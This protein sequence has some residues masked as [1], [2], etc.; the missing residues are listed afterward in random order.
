MTQHVQ[1]IN[2]LAFR[3]K[4]EREKLSGNNFNDWFRQLKLVLRVE[5]KMY[6]IEQPLPAAPAADSAAN[7]QAGVERFDLIQTFHA[8]KQEEGKS[9]VADNLQIKGYVDQLE[10]L[11]Y[12]LPQ[13]LITIGKL[14]AMLIEYEKGLPKNDETPQVMMIKDGKIQ[15]SKKKLL[16][17]KGKGKANGKENDKQLYIPKPKNPKPSAK[18]HPTKDDTCHHCKEVGHWKRNCL[19]YLTGV[20]EKE[21]SWL[22]HNGIHE[23]DMHDLIP[24]DNSIYD[25][26]TKRA[27]HNLDSTYLWHFHLAHISKKRI[28]KLQ[29]ER[30]LKSTNDGSFDQCVSCLSG[31]MTR[32][33]FLHRPER[34]TDL[35]GIIHIDMCGPLRHV[36]RQGA[37]Y[38]I[39]LT[40]DYSR[41][42][43]VYLLRHKHEVF[44]TFEEFKNEVENQLGK[45]I[46]ALR[47]DQG[48]EYISQEFKDHLKACG[49][50]QQ[51]THPYTPQ[52]NGDY[53]LESA[54]RILNIVPTKK[55]DKTP[56]KLC[57]IPMEVEDF[58]PSQE[59]VIIIRRFKRTNRTPNR[60]CLNVE[61]KEHTLGDLNE[62]A[63]YKAAMLDS[64]SNKWIDAMNAEIQS[65]IDNMVDY[66]ETVSPVTDIRAIRILI[67][68]SSFYDYEI[69]QID[70]KTAFLNGYFDEGIFMVQPEDLGEATFILGIK[71]YKDRS[72]RLIGL[73][74]NAY[75][76]KILKRY[77]IDNS[78]RGHIPMQE[79]L[80]LNK[81]QGASTPKEVKCMQKVPY[82]SA[83]G[84]IMY[85]VFS[86]CM[87][88]GGNTRDLGSFGEETV[89]ITDLHQIIEEAFLTKRIDDVASI[90][91]RRRDPSGNGVWNLETASG[92]DRLKE[93]L[94][95]ST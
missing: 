50:I 57:E 5:K 14:H 43:Y 56:Y 46:K 9:V 34:E 79:R 37:S 59:E 38:F 52:H 2:H 70:V 60:L 64:K 61:V 39:T 33:S 80:D 25:V 21:A 18:E 6:V 47:S 45:T 88:F 41:Y 22:C 1:N 62:P 76:D 27:K 93:D 91:Q 68:I 44:E 58:E 89:K 69:W 11:G 24:N 78:K 4:F 94:E 42:G 86:T 8:C 82:A 65:M 19:V 28:E 49:I 90:K 3:S 95:S 16:K 85:A 81:T 74:Q 72:K 7:K 32:K 36:S 40:D 23:I 73:G 15:K 13:D 83:V 53:A 48:G 66:E 55:V 77:K 87:V 67:S 20:E 51:L 54:T 12:M 92:R 71:I 35:L 63:S 10:R 30:L 31:K 17:A 26:N 84:S 75:M 29:Q